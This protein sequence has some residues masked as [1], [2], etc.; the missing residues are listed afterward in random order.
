MTSP[1]LLSSFSL[2]VGPKHHDTTPRPTRWH[3]RARSSLGQKLKAEHHAEMLQ[4]DLDQLKSVKEQAVQEVK[5]TVDAAAAHKKSQEMLHMAAMEQ[6]RK[7]LG[8][9]DAA[10]QAQLAEAKA[11]LEAEARQK[12]QAVAHWEKREEKKSEAHE[13]KVESLRLE[14]TELKRR[15]QNASSE[16]RR[17][18]SEIYRSSAE[19]DDWTRVNPRH[20]LAGQQDHTTGVRMTHGSLKEQLAKSKSVE[21]TLRQSLQSSAS[22][23]TLLDSQLATLTSNDH[24][25]QNMVNALVDTVNS[26]NIAV[27]KTND[28]L[29]KL[30][31]VYV[32]SQESA[33][34]TLNQI[35]DAPG[36]TL[37]HM[38][39]EIAGL[40]KKKDVWEMYHKSQKSLNKMM[41][42]SA[43]FEGQARAKGRPCERE[44]K[45][46][47]S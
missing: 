18:A 15:E 8:R 20:P 25:R 39:G 1:P 16:A 33:E 46:R 41:S 40:K 21:A 35:A 38:R 26:S 29:S 19:N 22:K 37:E 30:Q 4:H 42:D 44:K 31:E 5:R 3:P 13:R 14:L 36:A 45:C 23:V 27:Q 12:E 47:I 9:A 2:L 32:Q 10:L 28:S 7:G 17:M 34:R 24:E 6:L 43:A 11:S